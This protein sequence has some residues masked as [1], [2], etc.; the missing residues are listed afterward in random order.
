MASDKLNSENNF[1]KMIFA[2]ANMAG[3]GRGHEPGRSPL[4]FAHWAQPGLA[5][6]FKQIGLQALG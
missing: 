6:G 3:P 1:R 2:I 5:K 4:I